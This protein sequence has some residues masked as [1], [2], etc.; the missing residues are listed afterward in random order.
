VELAIVPQPAR[1][2]EAGMAN[3]NRTSAQDYGGTDADLEQQQAAQQGS[4]IIT[5]A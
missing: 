1:I 4:P 3:A 2:R 5:N